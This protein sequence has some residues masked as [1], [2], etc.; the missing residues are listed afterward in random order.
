MY[1][2]KAD[3]HIALCSTEP[4]GSKLGN[5]GLVQNLNLDMK[6]HFNSFDALKWI[7]KIIQKNAFEQTKKRPGL[8]FNP[9]TL[10]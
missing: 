2:H 4:G 8:Q 3:C 9:G 1:P 7:E 10:E 6:I 5:P